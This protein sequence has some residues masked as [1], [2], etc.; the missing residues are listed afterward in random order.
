QF[1]PEL[2]LVPIQTRIETCS[3]KFLFFKTPRKSYRQPRR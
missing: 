1:K 3:L 2:K